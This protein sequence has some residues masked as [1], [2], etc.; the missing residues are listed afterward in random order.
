MH[1]ALSKRNESRGT[2]LPMDVC[3]LVIR[4]FLSNMKFY[5][6]TVDSRVYI[7]FLKRIISAQ[8]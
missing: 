6:L 5:Y 7:L 4:V 3:R 2:S 8:I 1:Q